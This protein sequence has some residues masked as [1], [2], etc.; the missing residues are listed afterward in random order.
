MLGGGFGRLCW[1][2]VLKKFVD[3]CWGGVLELGV[4][5]WCWE[6]V[7]EVGFVSLCWEIL[8]GTGVRSWS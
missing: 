2:V 4:G 6:V 8:L 1:E 7:F 3:R 5:K